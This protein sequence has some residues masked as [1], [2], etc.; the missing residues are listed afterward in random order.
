M[1]NK[2][3]F[4]WSFI[5]LLILSSI[6]VMGIYYKKREIYLE[7]DK[8]VKEYLKDYI[9]EGQINIE[10]FNTYEVTSEELKNKGY[11][12][13]IKV[14]DMLCEFKA[15]IKNYILFNNY[16]IKYKC[17]NEIIE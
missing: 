12:E 9:K 3:I 13:E 11:F 10:K 14:N 4:L 16:Q 15:Y 1:S 7:T 6:F 8:I 17:I 2:V 5:V